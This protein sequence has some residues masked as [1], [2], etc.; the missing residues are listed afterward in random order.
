[1]MEDGCSTL[2]LD[3]GWD[4][5]FFERKMDPCRRCVC[6]RCWIVPSGNL[7]WQWEILIW[8]RQKHLSQDCLGYMSPDP[9]RNQAIHISDVVFLNHVLKV[10]ENRENVCVFV[11]FWLDKS[12]F[13][14]LYVWIYIYIYNHIDIYA[15][16]HNYV[17]SIGWGECICLQI[18][19][20]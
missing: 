7:T 12:D 13:K 6:R 18:S 10:D 16:T 15:Y 4:L 5:W 17:M 8:N 14:T 9:W 2:F 19:S 20:T 11:L 3:G 1:M